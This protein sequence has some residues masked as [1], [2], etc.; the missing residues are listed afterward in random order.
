MR[1]GEEEEEDE[2]TELEERLNAAHLPPHALKV[3]QKELKVGVHF[4]LCPPI[5]LMCCSV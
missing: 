5:M 2:L 1:G 3:A 4:Y